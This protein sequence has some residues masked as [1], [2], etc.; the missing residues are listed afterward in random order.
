L[1]FPVSE[2]AVADANLPSDMLRRRAQGARPR[3][4]RV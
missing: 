3:R 4:V 1:K 2:M